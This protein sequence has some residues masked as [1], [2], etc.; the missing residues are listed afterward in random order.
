MEYK[1]F[2]NYLIYK[3]G[4]IKSLLTG[5]NIKKKRGLG[6]TAIIKLIYALMENV[7]HLCFTD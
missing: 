4:T 2:A 1:Q 6:Q 7:K 3:D 5:K